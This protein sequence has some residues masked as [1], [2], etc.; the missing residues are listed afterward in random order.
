MTYGAAISESAVD[1]EKVLGLIP[2]YDPWKTAGD[3]TFDAAAADHVVGFFSDCLVHVKGEWAG[4]PV[5]LAPG[6]RR[7]S[8][9]SSGGSG[10]T[11]RGATA[12]R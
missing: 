8:G 9:T 3:C 2:G 6:S 12:R 10:P 7:S 1:W 4:K 5:D 11:A